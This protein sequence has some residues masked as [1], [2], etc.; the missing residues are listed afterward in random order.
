M[1]VTKLNALYMFP[2]L[3]LKTFEEDIEPRYKKYISGKKRNLVKVTWL[4]SSRVGIW[5][6]ICPAPPAMSIHDCTNS[7]NGVLLKA[8]DVVVIS[9]IT[10]DMLVRKPV[11][12][13]D[14]TE[15]TSY[16]DS[17]GKKYSHFCEMF[18]NGRRKWYTVL[19][20]HCLKLLKIDHK[21][22]WQAV[23]KSVLQ[24]R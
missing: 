20:W 19:P 17:H 6:H 24:S 7:F 11:T 3:I 21:M 15:F 9:L 8:H 1:L 4:V 2:Y 12:T 10:G 23:E 14:L 18:S 16:W 13:H 22:V 5:A